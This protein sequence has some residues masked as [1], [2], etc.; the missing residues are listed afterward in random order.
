MGGGHVYVGGGR[1]V[2]E[3]WTLVRVAATKSAVRRTWTFVRVAATPA[4]CARGGHLYVSC[5]RQLCVQHRQLCVSCKPLGLHNKF[6]KLPGCQILTVVF[7]YA[8]L[9]GRVK[10]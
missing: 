8:K 5:E 1:A 2:H 9:A 7:V 10:F 3:G 6:T 4:V